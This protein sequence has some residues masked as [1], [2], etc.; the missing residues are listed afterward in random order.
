[1]TET[2]SPLIITLMNKLLN[3]PNVTAGQSSHFTLTTR[4]LPVHRSSTSAVLPL[5]PLVILI[6]KFRCIFRNCKSK[7]KS[8][9]G[10][11]VL[12]VNKIRLQVQQSVFRRKW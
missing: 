3:L 6:Y 9:V 4:I 8:K 1:M 10:C 7:D 5:S 12:E 11:I 2:G